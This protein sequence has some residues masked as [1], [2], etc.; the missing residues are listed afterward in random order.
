MAR[1]WTVLR[2]PARGD[3]SAAAEALPRSAASGAACAIALYRRETGRFA[4]GRSDR[5]G[6]ARA[7]ME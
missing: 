4:R 1:T 7:A 3:A 5:A 6:H 2:L